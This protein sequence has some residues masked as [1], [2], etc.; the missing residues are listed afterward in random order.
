MGTCVLAYA[1]GLLLLTP[2]HPNP[3][4]CPETSCSLAILLEG[5]PAE[6]SAPYSCLRDREEVGWAP[7]LMLRGGYLFE[8]PTQKD[9]YLNHSKKTS[10]EMEHL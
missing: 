7:F 2:P 9:G 4:H 6:G 1:G 10:L 8:G 3:P 5:C